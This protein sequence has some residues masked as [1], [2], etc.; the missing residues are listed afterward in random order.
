VAQKTGVLAFVG[1]AAISVG[2][3]I[4]YKSNLKK[5]AAKALKYGISKLKIGSFGLSNAKINFNLNIINSSKENLQFK[6]F[7]GTLSYNGKK[8]SQVNTV[9]QTIQIASQ[10][11]SAIPIIALCTYTDLMGLIGTSRNTSKAKGKKININGIIYTDLLQI[12][13]NYDYTLQ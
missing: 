6:N 4:F 11:T 2:G 13:V 10:N 9:G 8:I 5:Q 7:N 3:Y 12:P 1:L